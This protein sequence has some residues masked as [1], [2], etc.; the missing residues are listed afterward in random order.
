MPAMPFPCA[1]AEAVA[2]MTSAAERIA[3][4]F[5]KMFLFINC[6][7]F[8]PSKGWMVLCRAVDTLFLYFGLVVACL[9]L[10]TWASPL[11]VAVPCTAVRVGN[12]ILLFHVR[13]FWVVIHSRGC[14]SPLCC[15]VS[16]T[17]FLFVAS[18]SCSPCPRKQPSPLQAC[19]S[20]LHRSGVPLSLYKALSRPVP[21]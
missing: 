21:S 19:H 16:R 5:F 13:S 12:V 9:F 18:R 3:F 6:S 7:C 11:R 4:L 8:L 20:S 14:R 17:P 1:K 15:Q 2:A 10:R